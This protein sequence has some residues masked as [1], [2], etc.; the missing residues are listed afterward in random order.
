MSRLCSSLQCCLDFCVQ[1]R[2]TQEHHHFNRIPG[3]DLNWGPSEYDIHSTDM[4]R[5]MVISHPLCIYIYIYVYI[6]VTF[7]FI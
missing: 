7:E 6:Y 5:D 3:R 2:E 4:F 1:R